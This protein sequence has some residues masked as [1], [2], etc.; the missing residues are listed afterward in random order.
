MKFYHKLLFSA[1]ILAAGAA[2]CVDDNDWGT[3]SSYNRLFSPQSL[4]VSV[5]STTAEVTFDYLTNVDYYLLEL[6]TDSL[7][8]DDVQAGSRI[9]TVRESPYTLEGLAGETTYFLRMK[10]CSY[11]D[12]APSLW[13]YYEDDDYRSFTTDGEQIFYSVSTADVTESTVLLTWIAGE[14]ATAIRVYASE[15]AF[16]NGEDPLQEVAVAADNVEAGEITITGL[17]SQTSYWFVIYNGDVKRGEI[18]ATTSA[19][20]PD[21][22]L[23]YSLEGVTRLGQDLLDELAAQAQEA[24]G[25]ASSYSLTLGVE[26]GTTLEVYGTDESGEDAALVLP[27]GLSVT[28]Y[29][30]PGERP[31]LSFP[32]SLDIEGTHAY[33]R[34]EGVAIA[35]DGCQYLVNQSTAAT[36]GEFTLTDCVINDMDRSIIRLQGSD[37]TTIGEINIDNTVVTNIGSGGYAVFRVDNSAY[38]IS[39]INVTNS[40]IN[41]V[42]HNFIQASGCNLGEVNFDG[43]TFY[44]APNSSSRY[45]V[46]ANGNSTN[47]NVENTL[48]G[49]TPGRGIR[50]GGTIAVYNS[51]KTSDGVFSSNDF[52]VDVTS[53]EATSAEVFADPDS[54]DFTLQLRAL[55]SLGIGDP[56]WYE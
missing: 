33:I 48:F 44:N 49:L 43:V 26:G 22:D 14:T 53:P 45:L 21:A 46:D 50:T 5:G 23:K 27:D 47:V 19:P 39:S 38:T 17:E 25:G 54:G 42:G 2:A 12:T 3:D 9:D 15:S 28:F 52:D 31:V 32:E 16:D 56:R 18:G 55:S 51:Y 7:Y 34:F 24:A 30:L 13:S 8:L 35:D 40:T 6:N 41:S 37:A 29:A 4:D 11:G 20:M 36:V 10:A 1:G